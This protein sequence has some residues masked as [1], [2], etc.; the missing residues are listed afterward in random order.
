MLFHP[1]QGVQRIEGDQGKAINQARITWRS[2]IDSRAWPRT[3]LRPSPNVLLPGRQR[4]SIGDQNSSVSAAAVSLVDALHGMD[5]NECTDY[6][7][8]A[9]WIR[10]P[11]PGCR[12]NFMPD[13]S[14]QILTPDTVST[15]HGRIRIFDAV[16]Y[17]GTCIG[18]PVPPLQLAT[19]AS[20]QRP[21]GKK[22]RWSGGEEVTRISGKM[23]AR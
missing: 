8:S 10:G 15:M 12:I 5:E 20:F 4:R 21:E 1:V 16:L 13:Q 2:G 14:N 23:V 6:F 3:G 18:N 22:C 9:E 11:Q 7:I 17:E 19:T